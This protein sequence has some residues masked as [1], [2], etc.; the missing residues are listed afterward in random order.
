MKDIYEYMSNQNIL[1]FY[2][3]KLDISIDNSSFF[4][5]KIEETEKYDLIID[6]SETY[7][8]YLDKTDWV[9]I[10]IDY[11]EIFDFQLYNIEDGEI[12]YF[13]VESI[14]NYL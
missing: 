12:E 14:I 9:D 6:N 8:F 10:V 2:G 11:S 1:N 5:L 7:D 3:S 4:D 13:D